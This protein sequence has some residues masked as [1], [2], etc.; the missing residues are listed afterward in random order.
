[1]HN[2]DYSKEAIQKIKEDVIPDLLLNPKNI[3]LYGNLDFDGLDI[4]HS[5]Y[6]GDDLKLNL[7][8][9]LNNVKKSDPSNIV[10][11]NTI[12]RKISGDYD[13]AILEY[14]KS[15]NEIP[16]HINIGKNMIVE[17]SDAIDTVHKRIESAYSYQRKVIEHI[18]AA[19]EYLDENPDAGIQEHAWNN[20]QDS[21]IRKRMMQRIESLN[22][23]ATLNHATIEQ[24]NMSM[25]TSVSILE[26]FNKIYSVFYPIWHNEMTRISLQSIMGLKTL[27][28]QPKK[29]QDNFVDVLEKAKSHLG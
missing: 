18:I 25:E 28:N 14:E 6:T 22:Q 16:T 27:D 12:L 11:N 4:P 7:I 2:V 26:V 8:S 9:L 13:I 17:M 24:L 23:V 15:R 1:M 10:R 19:R 20:T 5:V 3:A 21:S 29:A